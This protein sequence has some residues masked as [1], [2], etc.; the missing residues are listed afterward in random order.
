MKLTGNTVLITGGTS[1][2]GKGFAERLVSQN[3]TVI[4]CGRRLDQLDQ[5]KKTH[6]SIIIRQCDV[7]DAAKCESLITWIIKECPEF[8]MLINNAGIQLPT[9][10]TKPLDLKLIHEQIETNFVAP[11]YL[12]SLCAEHFKEKTAS[13]IIN[14]SSGLAFTPIAFMPVYCATKA[15]IHSMT[16]SL[17]KQLPATPIKVFEIA[18]PSVDTEL[19][20]QRREDK[21]QSHGGMP[22]AEFIDG[23]IKALESDTFEAGI[24]TAANLL[25]KREKLFDQMNS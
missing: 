8:N 16:L 7:N 18:P 19:G 6:P 2:I 9:D 17:R 20:H 5:I 12:T 22:V 11:M 14:I 10:L 4:V 1:G 25:D 13:A 23:A 21:S 3:N 15:A 24:G